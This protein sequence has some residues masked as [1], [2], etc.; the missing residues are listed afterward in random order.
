MYFSNLTVCYDKKRI[1]KDKLLPDDV[2]KDYKD[3]LTKCSWIFGCTMVFNYEMFKNIKEINIPEKMPLMHDVWLGL[4]GQYFGI[5]LYDSRSFILYRQHDNNAV[6]AQLNLKN[7]WKHRLDM[8][9]VGKEVSIAHRAEVMI[10]V[11]N[12]TNCNDLEMIKYTI[13]VRDYRKSFFNKIRFM[14]YDRPLKNGIKRG[15]LRIIMILLGRA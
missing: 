9:R 12:E 2:S 10:N 11:F 8:F 14:L 13:M 7:K 6:G 1:I 3:I 5:L 15:M 4:L